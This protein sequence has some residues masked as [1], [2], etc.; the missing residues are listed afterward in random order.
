MRTLALYSAV[1]LAAALAILPACASEDDPSQRG[2]G[3]K[4]DSFDA[5]CGDGSFPV[6]EIVVPDCPEGQVWEIIDGCF[7]RCVDADTCLP[8]DATC[9][10]LLTDDFS[11]PSRTFQI[12][13]EDVEEL[14]DLD[15]TTLS[16]DT[17]EILVT[18]VAERAGC[19]PDDAILAVDESSCQE[20]SN[21]APWSTACYVATTAGFFFVTADFFDFATVTFN[22]WD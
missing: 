3:G 14:D 13:M 2:S 16:S 17:A 19:D 20:L 22:V 4:A 9:D 15:D 8:P 6:C 21:G 18:A 11:A 12:W 10:Q 1:P 7:E 5:A